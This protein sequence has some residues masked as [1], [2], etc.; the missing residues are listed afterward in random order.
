MAIWLAAWLAGQLGWKPQRPTREPSG[1]RFDRQADG[2]LRCCERRRRR[3]HR[4]PAGEFLGRVSS[5]DR[6]GHDHDPNKAGRPQRSRDISG[7]AALPALRPSSSRSD[8]IDSCPLPRLVD[9]PELDPARRVAAALESSRVDPPFRA[10]SADRPLASGSRRNITRLTQASLARGPAPL[11]VTL[12]R[13][14]VTMRMRMGM[15]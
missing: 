9:A 2:N 7:S 1:R 5:A 12:L 14:L 4:D 13:F 6:G 8:A 3:Y 15:R 10:R 11:I